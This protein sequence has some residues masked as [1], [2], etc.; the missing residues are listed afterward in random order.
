MEDRRWYDQR[1][2]RRDERLYRLEVIKIVCQ[3]ITA[4]AAAIAS[5]YFIANK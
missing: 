2:E 1:A 4:M 5:A 3:A